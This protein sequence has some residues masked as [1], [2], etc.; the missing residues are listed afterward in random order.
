MI[1]LFVVNDF[2]ICNCF[3]GYIFFLYCDNALIS[4]IEKSNIDPQIESVHVGYRDQTFQINTPHT[5]FVLRT[6][7]FLDKN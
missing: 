1:L 5:N 6:K 4:F 3:Y 2:V 7:K